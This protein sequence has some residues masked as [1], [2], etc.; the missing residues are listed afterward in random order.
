MIDIASETLV[1]FSF[2]GRFS[3]S[4]RPHVSTIWRWH[5]RGIRGVKLESVLVGGRRMTSMEAVERF[6]VATTEAANEESRVASRTSAQRE[7]AIDRA[8]KELAKASI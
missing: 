4:I 5:M 7:A 3:P 6:I 1:S 2:A 8:E